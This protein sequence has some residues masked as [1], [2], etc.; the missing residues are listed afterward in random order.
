MHRERFPGRLKRSRAPARL[1]IRIALAR[2]AA[3]AFL[4]LA[5]C[6]QKTP[7]GEVQGTVRLDDR[8]LEGVLVVF[9]PDSAKGTEGPRS[10]AATDADGQYRLRCE[11][12]RDGAVIGWHRVVVEDMAVYDEPR[13]EDTMPARPVRSRVPHVY[14]NPAD[15]PLAAEVKPGEQTIDLHLTGR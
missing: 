6:A 1:A 3:L 13:D 12:L 7:L 4:L 8:P 10:T 2:G 15:S 9:L 11:D 14:T 5:G